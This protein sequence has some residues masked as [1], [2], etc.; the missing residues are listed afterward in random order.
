MAGRWTSHAGTF[1]FDHRDGA[2]VSEYDERSRSA[3]ATAAAAT[4]S[5]RL[6]ASVASSTSSSP[7]L[8]Q[9]EPK[10]PS[11]YGGPYVQRKASTEAPRAIDLLAA[12][13]R[14]IAGATRRSHT[15]M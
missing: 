10:V 2:R 4:T 7:L 9:G 14:G 12:A 8:S 15:P 1:S 3:R 13:A 6:A 11:W 5:G